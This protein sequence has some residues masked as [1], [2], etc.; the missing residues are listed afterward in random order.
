MA[1]FAE[2]VAALNELK[3]DRLVEDY[4]IGGA[5]AA[6]FWTEA[7]PTFDLDVLV[8]FPVNDSLL[9]SVEPIYVWAEE[10]GYSITAEHIIIGEVPVQF[11]PAY[12]ALAEE[13][14]REA[15]TLDYSGLPVRVVRPEHLIGLALEGSAKTLRR[16]ERAAM[17][18]E[19]ADL[20]PTVLEDVLRRYNL[21]W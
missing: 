12:S 16:R 9:V 18:K 8:L 14:V 20:D 7:I 17:L 19:S 13:A 10:R 4:A 21:S 1:S 3:Q 2:A 11:L 15:K 6:L 5:M